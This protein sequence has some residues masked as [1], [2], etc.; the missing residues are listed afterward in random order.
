MSEEKQYYAFISYKREDKKEAK[1]L[2]HQLEY[3]RLPNQLRK[4]NPDLPEYVRPVFRDMTDLE[5]GE[6]STLIHEAL[7]QS[8]YL[9]VVCSPRAAKSKWVNDEVEYFISLGKQDKIIPYIIEGVPHAEDPSEECYPPALLRLSKEKELLGANINEVGKEAAGIRVVAKMF[10]IRY[11]MLY[12]RYK[13]EQRRKKYVFFSF[14]SI[15]FIILLSFIGY[16]VYSQEKVKRENWRM[17]KN[18][19]LMIVEKANTLIDTDDWMIA[20]RLLLSIMPNDSMDS[21]MVSGLESTIRNVYNH[22]MNT[23]NP[24]ITSFG[25]HDSA[26]NGDYQDIVLSPLEDLLAMYNSRSNS[27]AIYH[28]TNGKLYRDFR[29]ER[30]E[31]I[32]NCIFSNDGKLLAAS[33]GSNG[34]VCVWDISS[35]EKLYAIER[36]EGIVEELLF[37]NDNHLMTVCYGSKKCRIWDENGEVN[38]S[39]EL[40]DDWAKFLKISP[41]NNYLAITT[42]KKEV[43]LWD[44]KSRHRI[45]QF[46]HQD[47]KYH[48]YKAAFDV[49]ENYLI[50]CGDDSVV[51][52]WDIAARKIVHA[53]KFD[54][55]VLEA[56]YYAD[57]LFVYTGGY[58]VYV[59]DFDY[60][61][62]KVFDDSHLVTPSYDSPFIHQYATSNSSIII[63]LASGEKY[64]LKN[65]RGISKMEIGRNN[66]IFVASFYDG[67][68]RMWRLSKNKKQFNNTYKTHKRY[69]ARILMQNKEGNLI[70][71]VY[72]NNTIRLWEY[73]SGKLVRE[74]KNIHKD[75]INNLSYDSSGNRVLSSAYDSTAI[76]WDLF[77]VRQPILLKHEDRYVRAYFVEHDKYVISYAGKDVYLWDAE[78][79]KLISKYANTH[80]FGSYNHHYL[81]DEYYE[82]IHEITFDTIRN[83]IIAGD[84]NG[85]LS[86]WDTEANRIIY[87]EQIFDDVVEGMLIEND[88]L[89][90]YSNDVI[91]CMKLNTFK[92]STR[93]HVNGNIY[94][95]KSLPGSTSLLICIS[96]GHIIKWNYKTNTEEIILSNCQGVQ[97]I[98]LYGTYIATVSGEDLL[99]VVNYENSEIVAKYK[100]ENYYGSFM[101]S[102]YD[103]NIISTTNDGSIVVSDFS[104]LKNVIEQLKMLILDFSLDEYEKRKYYLE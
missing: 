51:N 94:F 35:G 49:E 3:Y 14:I 95:V 86:C 57:C 10:G 44:L 71:T 22:F 31:G 26:G 42:S 16:I 55:Y 89:F 6:L 87:D 65:C 29:S 76:I 100:I 20:G 83:R 73:P 21:P 52:V 60:N 72:R 92:E 47:G 17:L 97:R 9:I 37:T 24:I 58:K 18:R 75:E 70:T 2:Q 33:G 64:V 96:D 63:D 13:R 102:N 34:K 25:L 103:H 30:F 101:F 82:N 23:E 19:N 68:V 98:D 84:G 90:A 69:N 91:K 1:R 7:E 48:L 56:I 38:D 39:L 28:T 27:I 93:L 36:Q 11:D 77:G 62:L 8:H 41:S 53:L 88:I 32:Y 50:T 79:G 12:Q 78:N 74:I 104:P 43:E 4:D 15:T 54:N 61:L 99:Y 67:Y 66:K 59:Y 45:Y 85:W 81:S 80:Q 5:V 46:Q 40:N